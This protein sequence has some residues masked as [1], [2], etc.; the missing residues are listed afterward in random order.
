[1]NMSIFD[2][3]GPVMIGPSS[4]HTAGAAR[5][6]RI[7]R[8][9]VGKPF[10]RVT[11]GLHGSFAKT[12]KG[13]GTDL[14]LV[15]GVLGLYEDDEKLSEAFTIA[16]AQGISYSF[17][18]EEL[19]GM[20]E[21]SVKM[22]FYLD[23]GSTSSIIGSSIGGAQI[24]IRKIN[25]FEVDFSAQNSTLIIKQADKK[26]IVSFI[27]RILADHDINIGVMKLSRKSKGD[28]AFCVIETDS[29][30]PDSAVQQMKAL[31]GVENVCAINILP[32]EEEDVQH[33]S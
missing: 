13:H 20:H 8:L 11:F 31:D 10:H 15:A 18:E 2:V 14:A 21:N 9:I 33:I 7:A 6:A 24:V 32:R 19:I 30:I 26:G 27:S 3:V 4:S 12:Y 16:D 22:T 5:L 25:N 29:E 17:Y 23:D 1:M 28:Q